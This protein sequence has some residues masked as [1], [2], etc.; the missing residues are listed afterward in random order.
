VWAG[1][2]ADADPALY[3]GGSRGPT[4]ASNPG[5]TTAGTAALGAVDVTV[6]RISLT[7]ILEQNATVSGIHAA[8][9]GCTAGETL[10][11]ATLTSS[12]GQL[13]LALPYGTWTIRATRGS[14]AGISTPVVV[15]PGTIPAVIVVVI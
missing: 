7:G 11:S 6:R 9:T 14:R 1:D 3:A 10:T 4:L 12:T 5:A 13:R 8:G 2:C 15:R